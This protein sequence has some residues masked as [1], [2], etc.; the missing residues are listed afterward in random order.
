M[1]LRK[2]VIHTTNICQPK[3]E[4]SKS[5][6]CWDCISVSTLMEEKKNLLKS[7]LTFD[8]SDNNSQLHAPRK[9]YSSCQE[10]GNHSGTS[11][12]PCP[13]A[14]FCWFY[15]VDIGQIAHFCLPWPFPTPPTMQLT[16]RIW[17]FPEWYIQGNISKGEGCGRTFPQ[18]KKVYK[19][20]LP[21]QVTSSSLLP[22][23]ISYFLEDV[24]G[25]LLL[26]RA[27]TWL[28]TKSVA[29][30][31][32]NRPSQSLQIHIKMVSFP[33]LCLICKFLKHPCFMRHKKFSHPSL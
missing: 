3:G 26:K 20:C 22:L 18:P 1:S 24:K 8:M 30:P 15:H 5:H 27:P 2:L 31:H 17:N 4:N 25:F 7:P 29:G 12:Q 21:N 6:Q 28:K 16:D 11:H 33:A 19:N 23:P 10:H 9:F 13:M 32:R 14:K